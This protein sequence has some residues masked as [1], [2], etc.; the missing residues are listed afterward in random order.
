[1]LAEI[2][3]KENM[4]FCTKQITWSISHICLHLCSGLE[5]VHTPKY[6]LFNWTITFFAL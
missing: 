6:E 3:Y 4:T 1:M 5:I 2:R